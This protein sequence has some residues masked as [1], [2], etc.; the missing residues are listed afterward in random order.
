V[1]RLV[2]L[3]VLAACLLGTLPLELLLHTR[4]YARWRRWLLAVLPVAAVFTLWDAYAIAAGH[5]TYDPAQT[6]GLL[7]P[8]RIPVEEVLFFLVV[9]TCAIL[10]FEAVRSVRGWPAGDE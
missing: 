10:A 8:G 6:T 3:A 9:P 1:A 2:Y 5:W 4:V 7:L